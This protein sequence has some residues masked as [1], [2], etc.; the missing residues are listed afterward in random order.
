[1]ARTYQTSSEIIALLREADS[2][3]FAVL[4][5]SLK[6]DT[7]KTVRAAVGRAQRRLE[8]EQAEK[9]RV[10]AL[11]QFE[12]ELSHGG[13]SVGL[14]EV[15]RGPLAGPLTV[16]AVVLPANDPIYGINDSKQLSPQR[17][18][19]LAASIKEHAI[20]WSVQ[21]IEPD[22][23]D[24]AGMTAS[25][26][27]AFKRA[28]RAIEDQG[29]SIDTVLLDGN[30]LHMDNREI[31]IVHGDARVASISCASIIAK[32]TRDALMVEYAKTYPEYGFDRNKGY[33]SKEHC[34]AIA[35]Y[36]LSPIHRVSF[37]E[38]LAQNSLF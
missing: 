25:L 5:R 37:C 36:G 12:S 7:R 20:A 30:P 2:E 23:I 17:R 29:I 28:I 4:E 24:A 16:G 15:G 1:M 38:S 35:Q 21:H 27:V 18:E 19:V 26:R 9:E 10:N 13:V 14:D 8:N 22:R 3:Q 34:D 33:G 31:S 6:A 32:V 11:Y